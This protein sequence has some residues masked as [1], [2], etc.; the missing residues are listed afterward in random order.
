MRSLIAAAQC[1]YHLARGETDSL[2][3]LDQLREYE[4]SAV[5][6]AGAGHNAMVEKPEAVWSWL[7]SKLNDQ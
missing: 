4:S 2:V 1:A 5:D 3:T 7:L 6:L